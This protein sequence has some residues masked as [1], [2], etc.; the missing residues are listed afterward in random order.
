MSLE[1]EGNIF[2]HLRGPKWP[3]LAIFA[4]TAS[5]ALWP[6]Q[7]LKHVPRR[8][9]LLKALCTRQMQPSKRVLALVRAKVRRETCFITCAS[10]SASEALFANI[11]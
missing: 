10:Q 4:N 6:A 1:P 7:V 3:F 8:A 5:L 2:E 9:Y 11:A